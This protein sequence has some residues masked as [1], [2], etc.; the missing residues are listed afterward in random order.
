MFHAA[1]SRNIYLHFRITVIQRNRMQCYYKYTLVLIE[2]SAGQ[3]LQ[4]DVWFRTEKNTEILSI[5]KCIFFNEK[6]FLFQFQLS[7]FPRV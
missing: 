4:K 3:K 5:F 1:C 6:F 7:V 2:S